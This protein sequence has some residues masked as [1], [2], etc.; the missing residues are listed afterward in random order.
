MFEE[1][2]WKYQRQHSRR[3][4]RLSQ[5]SDDSASKAIRKN[6]LTQAPEFVFPQANQ[7]HK[8]KKSDQI[9]SA[10]QRHNH[11]F[12]HQCQKVHG[13]RLPEFGTHKDIKY[14]ELFL[15]II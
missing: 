12:L 10:H 4:F 1:A 5:K 15:K 7:E 3:I 2:P 11:R 13:S 9:Q 14:P 8:A 6:H